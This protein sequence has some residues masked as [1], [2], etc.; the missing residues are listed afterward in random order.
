MLEERRDEEMNEDTQDTRAT[1]ELK[2]ELQLRMKEVQEGRET[3]GRAGI[4]RARLEDKLADVEQEND[5]FCK[6]LKQEEAKLA[7]AEERAQMLQESLTMTAADA[8]R[9]L[10]DAE[11]SRQDLREL[12]DAACLCDSCATKYEKVT[13]EP[14][15]K[16]EAER[17]RCMT[18]GMMKLR[19][20]LN[21][22]EQRLKETQTAFDLACAG[23][24]KAIGQAQDAERRA[25]D[26]ETYRLVL[27]KKN[28]RLSARI[29]E[30]VI[31]RN[32]LAKNIAELATQNVKL[33]LTLETI[34]AGR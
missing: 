2:E 18:D 12:L 13:G 21:D 3:I 11:N 9:Q 27:A 33:S 1:N 26:E 22:A 25:S 6:C 5:H 14:H 24:A 29:D 28:Q 4:I 34:R 17:L 31:E 19:A 10:A 23:Q 16:A 7:D 20:G 15:R 30:L 32:G 8:A